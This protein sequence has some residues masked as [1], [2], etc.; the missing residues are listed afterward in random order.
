MA[1]ERFQWWALLDFVRNLQVPR[2]FLRTFYIISF[3]TAPL[4]G[5][6]KT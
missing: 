1:H 6:N 2:K 4:H 3:F 5:E